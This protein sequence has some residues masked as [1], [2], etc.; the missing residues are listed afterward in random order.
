MHPAH[1][2]DL[3]NPKNLIEDDVMLNSS[4]RCSRNISYPIG[5]RCCVTALPC[6]C[7]T[8]CIC[9]AHDSRPHSRRIM[10][11]ITNPSCLEWE[12]RFTHWLHP[13]SRI[14]LPRLIYYLQMRAPRGHSSN[15]YC[16]PVCSL[17]NPCHFLIVI[18]DVLSTPKHSEYFYP[19]IALARLCLYI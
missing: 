16:V 13:I 1:Q 9:T 14:L 18:K 2:I 19:Y 11:K 4:E 15:F 6:L 3:L 8:R 17:L 10:Q 12:K 7:C 5:I